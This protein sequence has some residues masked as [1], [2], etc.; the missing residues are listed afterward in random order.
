MSF[1]KK[2]LHA[3][4]IRCLAKAIGLALIVWHSYQ[5]RKPIT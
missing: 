3:A 2:T 5:D 1:V 4:L